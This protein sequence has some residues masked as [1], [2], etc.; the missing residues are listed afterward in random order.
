MKQKVE[1]LRA[2]GKCACFVGSGATARR[3]DLRESET[4]T[5]ILHTPHPPISA[6]Y[7]PIFYWKTEKFKLLR[8]LVAVAF[9]SARRGK[10]KK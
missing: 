10:Y 6:E 2:P 7:A 5:V 4:N 8:K 9:C 3:S 1:R